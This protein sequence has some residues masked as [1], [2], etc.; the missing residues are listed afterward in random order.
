VTVFADDLGAQEFAGTAHAHAASCTH[1]CAGAAVRDLIRVTAPGCRVAV[2][3]WPADRGSLGA[4]WAGVAAAGNAPWPPDPPPAGH[5]KAVSS[6]PAG[7][8][9]RVKAA[10]DEQGA[11]YQDRDS[12]WR[13]AG[14]ADR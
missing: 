11:P 4:I 8:Q 10:Y 6:Q 5:G 9:A 7:V 14:P 3:V 1:L 12:G 13:R 2:T